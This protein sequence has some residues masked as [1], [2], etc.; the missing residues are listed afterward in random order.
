[1]VLFIEQAAELV[2]LRAHNPEYWMVFKHPLKTFHFKWS[3][4]FHLL[5]QQAPDASAHEGSRSQI[6]G[7]LDEVMQDHTLHMKAVGNQDGAWKITP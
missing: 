2:H 3:E 6:S 7:T 4:P 5:A 1:M